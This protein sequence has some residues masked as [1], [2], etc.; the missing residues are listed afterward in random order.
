MFLFPNPVQNFFVGDHENVS[1]SYFNFSM[2]E[3]SRLQAAMTSPRPP[4]QKED[5][6]SSFERSM[7][8]FS[9]DSRRS[10]FHEPIRNRTGQRQPRKRKWSSH[11]GFWDRPNV[12]DVRG[13]HR[14]DVHSIATG[15]V[16]TPRKARDTCQQGRGRKAANT[17][18]GSIG[19]ALRTRTALC[20]AHAME[21]RDDD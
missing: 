6:R 3:K 12:G 13:E 18:Q 10:W 1:K 21:R 2:F 17:A 11:E 8:P 19:T 5:R 7:L 15:G 14:V 9:D 20:G 4:S 16:T